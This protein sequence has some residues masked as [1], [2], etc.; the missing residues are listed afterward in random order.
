M[1]DQHLVLDIALIF[2]ISSLMC[3]AIVATRRHHLGFIARRADVRAV[4]AAHRLPTPRIGGLALVLGLLPMALMIRADL[5]PRFGLFLLSLIPVFLAGLLEDL[6]RSVAP[7]MRFLAAVLSSLIAVALLGVW[8][9]RVDVPGLDAVFQ[10]APLA[11]L[12]TAIACAGVCNGFNLIDGVNGLSAGV[13]AIAALAMAVVAVRGGA[14]I[15]V[16]LNL[17]VVAVLMGFLLFN[18]PWGRLFLGDAGAYSLGHVLAW[19]AISL[20]H[21]VPDLTPWALLLIFFWPIAD[22]FFAI[23][24]RRRAGRPATQPDRLHFHQLVMRAL[25]ITLTGRS[26]R[27]I[28]NPVATLLLLPMAAAPAFVGAML[29]NQPFAAF[30]AL[31]GFAVLFVATYFLGLRLAA[32][33]RR[34]VVGGGPRA[35]GQPVLNSEIVVLAIKAPSV[36]PGVY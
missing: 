16:E 7:R 17:M 4:Q 11:I 2:L 36:R 28:T 23:Y 8:V 27:H 9:S 15:L 13:G 19:F 31:I 35:N 1:I 3:A 34:R 12:F 14:P 25:E 20:M 5:A 26:A 22:T 30:L 10:W 6:G 18:Y 32:L 24:R 21:R 33:W 29:W